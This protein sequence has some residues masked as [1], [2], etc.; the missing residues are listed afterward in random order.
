MKF[1]QAVPSHWKVVKY[2]VKEG[3]SFPQ[4]LAD[5]YAVEPDKPACFGCGRR[6]PYDGMGE[7]FTTKREWNAATSIRLAQLSK[8][9]PADP[10]NYVLLCWYCHRV[11][12]THASRDAAIK[13]VNARLKMAFGVNPIVVRVADNPRYV[14]EWAEYV[15]EGLKSMPEYQD[16]EYGL[17]EVMDWLCKEAAPLV[18]RKGAGVPSLAK[19][20]SNWREQLEQV[21][22]TRTREEP[23][24]T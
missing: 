23:P 22:H 12:P 17:L 15:I 16:E 1:R 5:V 13:W 10:S 24:P 19:P 9:D 21:A 8:D 6:T 14:R 7:Q 20:P 4:F 18:G 2:W 3:E 11:M